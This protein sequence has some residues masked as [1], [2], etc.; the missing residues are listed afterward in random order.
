VH[1]PRHEALVEQDSFHDLR[2]VGEGAVL[3]AQDPLHAVHHSEGG[4]RADVA[5]RVGEDHAPFCMSR[6]SPDQSLDIGVTAHDPVQDDEVVHVCDISL[7]RDV[8]QTSCHAA[9]HPG[10]GREGRGLGVV[11]LAQ[12]E[13]RRP[14]CSTPEQLELDLPDATADLEHTSALDA[15]ADEPVNES[16]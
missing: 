5:R 11:G 13:I 4:H 6:R 10:L 12:L 3:A 15:L 2:W 9:R 8:A 1:V 14:G 16:P 7:D